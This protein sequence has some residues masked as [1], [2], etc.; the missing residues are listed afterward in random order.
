MTAPAG[1]RAVLTVIQGGRNAPTL[2]QV[3]QADWDETRIELATSLVERRRF[4][5]QA[6]TAVTSALSALYRPQ[7]DTDTAERWLT[8][9]LRLV[10]QEETRLAGV[11]TDDDPGVEAIA[12]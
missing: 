5:R 11:G 4:V 3:A 12:A 10:A 2:V 6:R 8:P 1:H 9:L 7:P